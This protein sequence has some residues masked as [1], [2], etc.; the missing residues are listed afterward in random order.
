[1]T[2]QGGG[3]KQGGDGDRPLGLG[4]NKTMIHASF[5]SVGAGE[6]TVHSGQADTA[7]CLCRAVAEGPGEGYCAAATAIPR[8]AIPDAGRHSSSAS[9]D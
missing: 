8:H 1:M 3:R 4:E 7:G 6:L 5:T 2:G 9:E